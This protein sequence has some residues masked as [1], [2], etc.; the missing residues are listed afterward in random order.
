MITVRPN[1]MPVS[2]R[3]LG[4]ACFVTAAVLPQPLLS[5]A[6]KDIAGTYR[7]LQH[8]LQQG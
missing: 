6:W 7:K 5:E 1:G 2:A 3:F 4:T 8:L